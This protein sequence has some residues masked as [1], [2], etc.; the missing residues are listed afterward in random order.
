[1]AP[2][3]PGATRERADCSGGVVDH[4]RTGGDAGGLVDEDEGTVVASECPR[5]KSERR[6][7]PS[8]GQKS[9]ERRS[10]VGTM[11]G[12]R[13]PGVF[14][15]YEHVSR[16]WEQACQRIGSG[17]EVLGKRCVGGLD[18]VAFGSLA[19][20]EITD[21]SDFDYLVLA[22]ELP[23]DPDATLDLLTVADSL[24]RQWA[25][26]DGHT[27]EVRAPGASGVF[28]QAVGAFELVH[29]IGLQGDTNHSLTRRMLLLEESVSLQQS[30][31][32]EAVIEATLRRYLQVGGE[33]DKGKVPRFL[34]NDVTRYWRTIT[35]DYQ[36]KARG[37]SEGAGLRYLKLIIPRK[38]L[39][40][41]TVMSLLLC[42]RGEHEATIT[43]LQAQFD[44]TPVERLVQLIHEAPE[45]V[46]EAMMGVLDVM[47]HYLA[48]SGEP[49]WRAEVGKASKGD[50]CVPFDEM[51]SEAKRLQNHLETIFF[52]WD[53]LRDRSR[54][55]L[56]F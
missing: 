44:Q 55:T 7:H 56:V 50:G 30:G 25:T 31:V 51:R 34:L 15:G 36:A 1:M 47:D 53:L 8:G 10:R 48:R 6:R 41:G 26:E 20:R 12:P 18:V 4:A 5:W 22:T 2:G 21:E 23:S 38:I 49:L 13:A 14:T 35:V 27:G 17:R 32:R 46:Q 43:D 28:G 40:A 52:D 16:A 39:F 29:Q 42:G 24:R 45:S 11:G 54:K 9:T 19:R 3:R 33:M 37:S